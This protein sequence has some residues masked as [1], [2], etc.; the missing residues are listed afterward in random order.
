MFFFNI[1]NSF[2]YKQCPITVAKNKTVSR[3][4]LFETVLK[5]STAVCLPTLILIRFDNQK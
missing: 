3:F 1:G 5:I 2:D 4:C